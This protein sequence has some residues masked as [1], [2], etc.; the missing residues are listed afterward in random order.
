MGVYYIELNQAM[1]GQDYLEKCM[2]HSL[3]DNWVLLESNKK[4][5]FN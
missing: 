1:D 2:D 3:V 5:L 4:E